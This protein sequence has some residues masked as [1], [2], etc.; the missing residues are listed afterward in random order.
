VNAEFDMRPPVGQMP[1]ICDEQHDRRLEPYGSDSSLNPVTSDCPPWV[2]RSRVNRRESAL[3]N[4]HR[5][6]IFA[7]LTPYAS[8]PMSTAT[9]AAVVALK[10]SDNWK[11]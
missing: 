3:P 11:P 2:L 4:A 7:S 8:E 5:Q 6:L 10:T 9:R 1:V